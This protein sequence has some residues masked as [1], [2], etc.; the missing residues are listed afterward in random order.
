M[1][2]QNWKQRSRYMLSSMKSVQ[3]G[4]RKYNETEPQLVISIHTEA[5][6]TLPFISRGEFASDLHFSPQ[7][8]AM[9]S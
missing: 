6:C 2:I 3:F 1:A 4:T 8:S 5:Q 9:F 7:G